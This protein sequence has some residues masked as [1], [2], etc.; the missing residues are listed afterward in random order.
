MVPRAPSPPPSVVQVVGA[1]GGGLGA[2]RL[3]H[4]GRD[5]EPRLLLPVVLSAPSGSRRPRPSRVHGDPDAGSARRFASPAPA[6]TS[7]SPS[8]IATTR[9]RSP[10]RLGAR[11]EV[12]SASLARSSGAMSEDAS[13][14]RRAR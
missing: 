4:S 1:G 13:D 12:G 9:L 11:D 14:L 8:T 7:A 10:S 2:R 6:T 5:D 3:V